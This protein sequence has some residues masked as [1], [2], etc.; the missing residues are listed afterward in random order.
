MAVTRVTT[1]KGLAL[2]AK[3]QAGTGDVL[4]PLLEI[5]ADAGRSDDLLNLEDSI[6]PRLSFV[7]EEK[8]AVEA[9][10][11]IRAMLTNQGNPMASPPIPPL[12]TGFSMQMMNFFAQDPDEGRILYQ[13]F[14]FDPNDDGS[15]IPYVPAA[16]ERLWTY[17]PEFTI[18]ISDAGVVTIEISPNSLASRESIWNSTE[19]SDVE[20][21]SQGVRTHL[22]ILESVPWT[23]PG[24]TVGDFLF[25]G[26]FD[27]TTGLD[28][29]GEPI[30]D[31]D[32]DNEG[33]YWEASVAGDF[34][35]PGATDPLTFAV[36][37]WLV[38]DG[39]QFTR[40][41]P[42]DDP[43][44][45][46]LG[47]FMTEFRL[48]QNPADPNSPYQLAL[49]RN[50]LESIIDTQTGMNMVEILETDEGALWLHI[51]NTEVHVNPAWVASMNQVVAE[52]VAF[53]QQDFLS[54]EERARWDQAALDAAAALAT[55]LQNAGNIVDMQG[56]IAQI[57]ESIFHAITANPFMVTFAN[58]DGL[59]IT[60]GVWN[61]T[62][63]RIEC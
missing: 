57:Q 38:S 49:F 39:T 16:S 24:S 3:I 50:I 19:M 15:G 18:T 43:A 7:F 14:R 17:T 10:A 29:G 4:L 45:A 8:R 36:G 5:V 54:P 35:P 1:A 48:R 31:P 32:M 27:P 55:A 53:T 21:P 28:S 63:H 62:Y 47:A 13:V 59:I 61:A 30:P 25:Q 26:T 9:H 12:V 52:L 11:M 41:A 34:T 51:A 33:F 42:V 40:S 23:P 46:F 20:I 37:D 58:L 44:G 60:R 22:R 2:N 6:D 56:Q